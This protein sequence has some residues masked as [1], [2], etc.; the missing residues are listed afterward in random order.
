MMEW[1]AYCISPFLHRYDAVNSDW[2]DS[3]N[4]PLLVYG[5]PVYL[6]RPIPRIWPIGIHSIVAMEMQFVDS[7]SYYPLAHFMVFPSSFS[8]MQSLSYHYITLSS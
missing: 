1:C 6:E 4:E 2:P 7:G 5:I 8:C 3:G